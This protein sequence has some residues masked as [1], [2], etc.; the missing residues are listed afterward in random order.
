MNTTAKL[1]P[2]TVAR[3]LTPAVNLVLLAMAR[4]ELL[5]EQVDGLARKVLAAGNY[6]S[7]YTGRRI[8][9]P[10]DAWT[11]SARLRPAYHALIDTELR[12]A[13]F[14]VPDGYCPA[15]MAEVDQRNAEHALIEASRPFF[16]VT[17]DNL[18]RCR[19]GLER[20]RQFL[21]LL[22]G[23]CVNAPSYKSPLHAPESKG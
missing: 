17:T 2:E 9:N 15:L 13:G 21:D 19:H 4:A 23:V 6:T 10:R 20:R 5:R 14:N 7:E 22:I 12:A 18:L 1:D 16:G 3:A 8:T 11:M